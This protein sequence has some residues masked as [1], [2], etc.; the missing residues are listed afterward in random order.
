M[1]RVRSVFNNDE[2]FHRWAAQDQNRGR[3]RTDSVHYV[4]QTLF[5]YSTPIAHIAIGANGAPVVIHNTTTYSVTTTGHQH[6]ARHA[7]RHIRSVYIEGGARGS[8]GALPDTPEQLRIA[9]DRQLESAQHATATARKGRSRAKRL[10]SWRGLVQRANDAAE[11]MGFAPFDA[12]PADADSDALLA[13]IREEEKAREAQRA[14]QQ[15]RQTELDR[16]DYQTRL[17]AWLAGEDVRV[18][19]WNQ[20]GGYSESDPVGDHM[21]IKGSRIE[22]TRGVVVPVEDVQRIAPVVLRV[23]RAGRTY[24]ANGERIAVGVY[25]LDS[26]DGAGTVRVGCHT[27]QRSEIERVAGLLNIGA[28]TP[29]SSPEGVAS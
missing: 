25:T 19:R 18:T 10:E 11:I 4:G 14:E 7:V 8:W 6:S 5:S 22:T 13:R 15:R 21:R 2:V 24:Q 26:I 28:E 3:N 1:M 27:F 9:F 17:A 12:P 20:W 16:A 23:I 29:A